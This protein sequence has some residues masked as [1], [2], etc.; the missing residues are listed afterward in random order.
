V[1]EPTDIMFTRHQGHAI[2]VDTAPE[3]TRIS[4]HALVDRYAYLHMP[5]PDTVVFADQVVYRITGYTEGALELELVEDWRPTASKQQTQA[6]AVVPVEG[7]PA[8]A[9][10]AIRQMDADPHG[11]KAGMTVQPYR[12]HGHEKWVFRCWGTDT[13][14]GILSLDHTNQQAAERARDRHL[15][16]GHPEEK[17]MPT[18][19]ATIEGPHIPGGGPVQCTREAGHPE[20]H[21]GPQQGDDGKT[22]WTDHHAGATPHRS[23]EQ[24]P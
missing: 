3:H 9:Q 19:T 24:Q 2:T 10:E 8:A 23:E 12:E 16:E 18:C 4:L 1:T 13:C 7:N 21:V 6:G 15:A 14:D 5:T 20:N 22:L 17:P 11:L